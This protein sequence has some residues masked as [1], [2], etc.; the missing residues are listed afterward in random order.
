MVLL[1]S[2]LDMEE[3]DMIKT[4]IGVSTN[5]IKPFQ[6]CKGAD[7]LHIEKNEGT[8]YSAK[9][10]RQIRVPIGDIDKLRNRIKGNA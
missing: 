9:T 6:M 5:Q 8:H 10:D 3:P 4:K 1:F 2:R 7:I